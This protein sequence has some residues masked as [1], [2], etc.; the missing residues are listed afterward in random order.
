MAAKVARVVLI[1]AVVAVLLFF[2]NRY[3][4]ARQNDAPSLELKVLIVDYTVPFD[5]YR[6]HGGL[7]WVLNHL[8]VPPP[9]GAQASTNARVPKPWKI[10]SDYVGYKPADREHPQRV[11][12]VD[13]KD[14]ELVYVTDTY[15][16]YD[17]DLI[18]IPN[19]RAHMD[20]SP[21]SFG[22]LSDEDAAA[23]IAHC[24]GGG[25]L[26]AEFNS[27]CTPTGMAARSAMEQ[28]LGVQWSGWVG[29]V[30]ADPHDPGDAPGWL[31]RE[32]V[33]QH[34]GKSLPHQPSI[35]FVNLD[36]TL[37]LF[38]A[39]TLDQV[40]P[41]IVL[42][43][44]GQTL[45]PE[46]RDAAPYFYWFGLFTVNAEAETEVLARF[47]LP[48]LAGISEL[49]TEIDVEEAPP[50][51]VSN[52]CAGG[53]QTL[54]FAGDFADVD[55]DPGDY[56][57]RRAIRDQRDVERPVDGPTTA[58]SFWR[59]YAPLLVQVLKQAAV[60]REAGRIQ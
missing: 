23:L 53:G 13:L 42:S 1:V 39:D 12:D 50:L 20:Y 48:A 18:D 57:A 28:L 3:R 24:E 45:A 37:R 58:P 46:A 6:E 31:E 17:D 27:F 43:E 25:D 52:T 30:F 40:T 49:M 56:K 22:G 10:E 33:R 32:Y 59:F 60:R 54:Y 38:A 51:A 4:T 29:R 14:V 9:A 34:P 2:V 8:R 19:K 16:V 11:A 55:F 7:V 41:H 26:I 47:Q 44:A 36:G 35:I 15:G 21:L 5:N